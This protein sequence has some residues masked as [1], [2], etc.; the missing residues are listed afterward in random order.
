[1]AIAD[2][3][4]KIRAYKN[5]DEIIEAA[6]NYKTLPD[7]EDVYFEKQVASVL[8]KFI[9]NEKNARYYIEPRSKDLKDCRLWI[10]IQGSYEEG[11]E[12]KLLPYKTDPFSEVR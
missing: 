10:W 7:D 9:K 8:T 11:Y 6:Y 1:M 5:I 3:D 4:E 12:M 2:T